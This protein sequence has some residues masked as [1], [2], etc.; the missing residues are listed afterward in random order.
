MTNKSHWNLEGN[1]TDYADVMC[2]SI[3]QHKILFFLYSH[4]WG[5]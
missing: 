4:S 2:H 5:Y 3:I 1:K